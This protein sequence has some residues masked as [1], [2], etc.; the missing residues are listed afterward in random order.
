MNNRRLP[1]SSARR[2]W[3]CPFGVESVEEGFALGAAPRA[4]DLGLVP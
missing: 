3:Q 4:A 1:E 2:G